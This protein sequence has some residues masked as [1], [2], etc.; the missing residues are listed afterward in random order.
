MSDEKKEKKKKKKGKVKKPML[1]ERPLL[2]LPG[3]DGSELLTIPG[4]VVHSYRHMLNKLN[5]EGNSLPKRLSL[6][7]ALREEGVTYNALALATT[8]AN[9]T[10]HSI[11]V[12]ELNWWWPGLAQLAG[13]VES[14]GLTAVLTENTPLDDVLIPTGMDNLTLLPA[15]E[16]PV[17]QRPVIACSNELANLIEQLSQ[18]FDYLFLDIPAVL[19]TSDAITLATLGTGCCVVVRQGVTPIGD[20]KLALDDIDHIPMLGVIMNKVVI[21]TPKLFLKIIPQ[22]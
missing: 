10:T 3:I 2:T 17:E 21:K 6:V 18:Q 12:V 13:G 5:R 7:S 22:G 9:D 4:E 1:A 15:G 16:L 19:A 14:R 11:C 20:V 8:M